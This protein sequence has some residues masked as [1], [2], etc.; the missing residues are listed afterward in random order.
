MQTLMEIVRDQE[1]KRTREQEFLMEAQSI[2]RSLGPAR[3]EELCSGIEAEC[4]N[5]NGAGPRRMNV[6]RNALSMS[7]RDSLT[8]RG[9]RLSYNNVGPC[10]DWSVSGGQTRNMVFQV[11]DGPV[12]AVLLVFEGCPFPLGEIVHDLMIRIVNG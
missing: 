12:P 11:A 10:I 8:G 7:V 2:R 4:L 1:V 5:I 6:N 9:L 3:W